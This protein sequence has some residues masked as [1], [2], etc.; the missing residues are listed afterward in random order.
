MLNRRLLLIAVGALT[1]GQFLKINLVGVKFRAI[2]TGKDHLPTDHHPTTA[3][4]AR[5]IDHDRVEAGDGMDVMSARCLGYGA[6]H[7]YRAGTD[8][9]ADGLVRGFILDNQL[10]KP[11][12]DK[13][14]ETVCSIISARQD[15]IA[16]VSQLFFENDIWLGAATNDGRYAV[17]RSLER[18]RLGVNN[19]CTN[20]AAHNN[21]MADVGNFSWF[22][23][24]PSHISNHIASLQG[25]EF[26]RCG[27]NRLNDQ[28]DG[29]I[30]LIGMRDGQRNAFS[31]DRHAHND[32][33]SWLAAAYHMRRFNHETFD[34]RSQPRRLYNAMT[35]LNG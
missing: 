7:G 19:G 14:V 27:A 3:A 28:C 26:L 4:H 13:T 25:T 11:L 8:H 6:H 10:P 32:E 12:G 2:D 21:G 9:L 17:S 29:T 23:Q 31:P 34:L 22:T 18:F 35:H 20:P 30:G 5:A 16:N 24:W 15:L 33:L 1:V